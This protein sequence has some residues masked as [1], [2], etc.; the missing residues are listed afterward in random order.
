MLA[1]R[2]MSATYGQDAPWKDNYKSRELTSLASG[3]TKLARVTFT[4]GALGSTTPTKLRFMH[5]GEYQAGDSF[6]SATVWN[7]PADT[8]LPGKSFFAVLK[9]ADASEGERL[10]ARAATG[11]AESGVVVPFSAVVISGGRYWCYVEK[12]PGVFARTE[13]DTGMPTDHGYFIKGPI[14]AGANL[15]TSSAGELLARETNPS[16]AAD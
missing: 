7:A 6:E 9:G 12:R 2:R 15:V 16:T 5:I 13:I 3:E 14:T 1:E 10:L 11:E 4:L 8:S